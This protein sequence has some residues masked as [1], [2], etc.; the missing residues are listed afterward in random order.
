MRLYRFAD[1]VT[2]RDAEAMIAECDPEVEFA[3]VLSALE[4]Q[5]FRGPDGLRDYVRDVAGAWDEWRVELERVEEAPDGRVA[6]AMTMHLR[7]QSSGLEL[8]RRIGHLWELRD[9]K[10]W[11]LTPYADDP[12]APFR[13]TGLPASGR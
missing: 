5:V 6:A 11:R 3:S 13:E 8:A 10:L 12:E 1:A 7:G 4:N 9:G 2:R